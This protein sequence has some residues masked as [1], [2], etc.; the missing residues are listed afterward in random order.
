MSINNSDV[1]QETDQRKT[2]AEMIDFLIEKGVEVP[3]SASISQIRTLFEDYVRNQAAGGEQQQPLLDADNMNNRPPARNDFYRAMEMEL[4]LV[5]S[6]IELAKLNLAMCES[7]EH[8][9]DPKKEQSCSR[10]LQPKDFSVSV[11]EFDGEN[12]NAVKWTKLLRTTVA[13]YGG[14]E[15]DMY[16]VARGLITG[17][18]RGHVNQKELAT[19]EEL[20]DS[21]VTRFRDQRSLLD[22]YGE[23]T[24]RKKKPDE[25]FNTYVAD[26]RIP[27]EDLIPVIVNGLQ[28]TSSFVPMLATARTI[29][30]L[31]QLIPAYE[32]HTK[33]NQDNKASVSHGGAVVTYAQQPRKCYYCR[34]PGHLSA[35]CPQWNPMKGQSTHIL[36]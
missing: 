6:K 4:E 15:V 5:R 36:L 22:I 16:R 32:R 1:G 24:A 3:E 9:N 2:M 23:L 31:V 33:L 19:W 7:S 8:K 27:A 34:Q 30:E 12:V 25:S 13:S 35:Q 29:E 14:T 21:L 28:E 26:D 20:R 18:A 10:S 17:V 11:G